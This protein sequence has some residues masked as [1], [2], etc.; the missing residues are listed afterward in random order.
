MHNSMASSEGLSS[1]IEVRL[2]VVYCFLEMSKFVFIISGSEGAHIFVCTAYTG[3]VYLYIYCKSRACKLRVF[4][5][6][7]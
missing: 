4:V 2:V 3:N 1:V 5:I 7:K 6:C